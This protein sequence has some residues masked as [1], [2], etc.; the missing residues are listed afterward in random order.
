M[1]TVFQQFVLRACISRG[2]I[3]YR[4]QNVGKDATWWELNLSEFWG[5][6]KGLGE[7]NSDLF[8]MK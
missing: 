3:Y 5:K 1:R 6:V 2:K 7:R 8:K 4:K